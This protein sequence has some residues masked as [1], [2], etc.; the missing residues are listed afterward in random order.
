[1]LAELKEY[2]RSQLETAQ[3]LSPHLKLDFAKMTIHTKALQLMARAKKQENARLLEINA[4]INENMCL[5]KLY[6]DDASQTILIRELEVL[7]HEKKQILNSQGEHLADRARTKWY[8][9][10]ER[11]NKY[12]LN[13][14]KRRTAQNE[15]AELSVNGQLTNDKDA[16]RNEVTNFYHQLYNMDMSQLKIEGGFL[17][18]MFTVDPIENEQ[19]CAPIS[20]NELWLTLKPTRA[21]TPGPDG[22]SNTYLKKLWDIMGP[23]IVEAWTYSIDKGYLPPSHRQSILRLIPKAGKDKTQIKNWRP[24]T[25]SNCDHKLIT[26]LYNNRI[27]KVLG[28]HISK[29]QTAYIRGRNI[30]DNLRLINSVNNLTGCR[31]GVDG[32]LI[33][34]DAQKA[35]DSVSHYYIGQLLNKIGLTNFVPLFQLLYRDLRND[36]LINGTIGGGY[37]IG[38]GVKQGDALSCSLFLLAIEPVIRNI[39]ANQLIEPVTDN[40]LQYQ[41]PKTLAYADDITVITRNSQACVQA[42]FSEYELLTKASGI[43]LNADKT[44]KFDVTSVN[45]GHPL[46]NVDISYCDEQY[47][48]TPVEFVKINGITFHRDN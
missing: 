16:I 17:D 19:L 7:S 29:T 18:N 40:R 42:I 47:R 6:A 28:K 48:I 21:T 3:Y 37:R 39:E 13:L 9:E 35:F 10:G 30:A 45:I 32:T 36:I 5:V 31:K 15:M 12:F 43:R 41:W 22:L 26:R 23:L 1:M 33:A 8:N 44:E 11:S 4:E 25:L 38:N 24:I 2:L 27:L 14:L 34:L 20:I 46:A